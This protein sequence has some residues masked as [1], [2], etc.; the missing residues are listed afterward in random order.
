MT[1]NEFINHVSFS[2]DVTTMIGN[3]DSKRISWEK[4]SLN[5]G[6]K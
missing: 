6:L 4:F 2:N 3:Y 5:E 1:Q